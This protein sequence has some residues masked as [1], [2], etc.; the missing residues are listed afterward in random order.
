MKVTDIHETDNHHRI[1]DEL[2]GIT[3]RLTNLEHS[4]LHPGYSFFIFYPDKPVLNSKWF[5]FMRAKF[6]EV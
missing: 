5:C 2:I 6:E 1:K 4:P 3:G